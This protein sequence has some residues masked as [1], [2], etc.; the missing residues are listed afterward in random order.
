MPAP[1]PGKGDPATETPATETPILVGTETWDS[2]G[3]GGPTGCPE[4]VGPDGAGRERRG[5]ARARGP[6]K[7]RG[8]WAELASRG[9]PGGG[10]RGSCREDVA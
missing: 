8:M 9:C 7:G 2:R 1:N 5:G 4:R 6:L 3:A 10:A